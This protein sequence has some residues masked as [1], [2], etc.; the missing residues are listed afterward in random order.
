MNRDQHIHSLRPGVRQRVSE[1]V[2]SLIWKSLHI[3]GHKWWLLNFKLINWSVQYASVHIRFLFWFAKSPMSNYMVWSKQFVQLVYSLRYWLFTCF[4][5]TILLFHTT[6]RL[7]LKN[8][9]INK[10]EV[11]TEGQCHNPDLLYNA[12]IK[13]IS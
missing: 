3:E 13:F 10:L 5:K 2:Y 4:I 6:Y 12:N 8:T 11:G 1:L 9:F 7:H